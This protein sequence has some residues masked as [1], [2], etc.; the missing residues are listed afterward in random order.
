VDQASSAEPVPPLDACER[1]IEGLHDFFVDWYTGQRDDFSRMEAAIGN[2][3]ELVT[4]D[5][6]TLD[7]E[8]T[9]EMVRA[10]HARQPPGTF[11][12]EIRNVELVERLSHPDVAIVQYEEWQHDQG[13]TTGRLSTVSFHPSDDAP[14]GV[15]WTHLREMWIRK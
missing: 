15:R 14:E 10:G 12:I 5:G 6:E 8:E 13:E 2:S 1:E 9:L 11:D 3:F 4:P 7:R